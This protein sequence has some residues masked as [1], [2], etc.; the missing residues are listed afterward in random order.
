MRIAQPNPKD[1]KAPGRQRTDLQTW[2]LE[3]SKSKVRGVQATSSKDLAVNIDEEPVTRQKWNQ[4]LLG[5][6]GEDKKLF[7]C[8]RGDSTGGKRLRYPTQM[9]MVFY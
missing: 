7:K 9:E 4:K 2:W 5:G 6:G 8:V 1:R 3:L